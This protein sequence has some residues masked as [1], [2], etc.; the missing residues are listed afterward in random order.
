[1]KF[2]LKIPSSEKVIDWAKYINS[3]RYAANSSCKEL[4]IDLDSITFLRPYHI[5]ILSCLI[6]EYF[7]KGT[8]I[9]FKITSPSSKIVKYLKNIKFLDYWSATFDQKLI[10]Q[11]SITT[12]LSLW[13][14][15][16]EMVSFY[17]KEAQDYY[18]RNFFQNYNLDGLYVALSELFNN[19]NDHSLSTVDGYVLTQFYPQSKT[20]IIAVCDFGVGVPIAINKFFEKNSKPQLPSKDT[21]SLAFRDGFSIFSS[22]HN[23]GIG[24][25]TISRIVTALRGSVTL[26]SN[27][28]VLVQKNSD[29]STST[30][31]TFFPGTCFVIRLDTRFLS[32]SD[33]EQIIEEFRL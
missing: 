3:N 29:I 26:I 24:L 28:A 17:A 32:V 18:T 20:I 5:V 16:K 14:V 23:R 9:S 33:D 8:N 27:D 19:I 4:C 6:E 22:P 30:M 11:S 15:H 2:T 21:L 12:A 25:H 31:S 1:M 10:H 13:K 7:L